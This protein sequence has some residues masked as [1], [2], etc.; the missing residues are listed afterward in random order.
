MA[1]EKIVFAMKTWKDKV[2]GNTP[3]TAAELNR[4]EKGIS[5]CAKQTNALGDSV[6]Q[7]PKISTGVVV[8]KYADIHDSRA[9]LLTRAAVE[10]MFGGKMNMDKTAVLLTNS[11]ALYGKTTMIAEYD[12]SDSAWYVRFASAPNS[13]VQITYAVFY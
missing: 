4:I 9:L 12:D 7:Q 13:N 2:S 5:D 8:I 11:N 10:S 6:S 1:F 3:V